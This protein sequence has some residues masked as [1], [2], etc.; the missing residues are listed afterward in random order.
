MNNYI[1]GG[2]AVLALIV[3]LVGAFKPSVIPSVVNVGGSA[4]PTH[5]EKQEFLGGILNSGGVATSSLSTAVTVSA[6]DFRGWVSSSGCVS[7]TPNLGNITLT[8]PASSTV[9]DVVPKANDNA[10]FCIRNA[11]TT[12]NTII[13]F[14][15]GTGMN[16]NVAS[17]SATVLG[18]TKLTPGEVGIFR[19]IREALT[20]TTFDIKLLYTAFQ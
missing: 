6:N 12:A 4:G 1:I 2:I 5:T 20:A 16:L 3:A 7:Y 15:V 14:A 11:T 18:S 10:T 9:S 19:I 8:F 13:T 17:S